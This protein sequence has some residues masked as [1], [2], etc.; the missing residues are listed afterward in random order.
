MK[1]K[2]LKTTNGSPDGI[3]VENYKEGQEYDLDGALLSVFIKLGVAEQV[4]IDAPP[5]KAVLEV[6]PETKA[7]NKKKGK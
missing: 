6:V 5:E 1:I 4:K 7:T 2:M 3:I